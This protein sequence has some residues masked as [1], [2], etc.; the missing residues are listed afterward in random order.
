M[1]W[2]QTTGSTQR[3]SNSVTIPVM[4]WSL[5]RIH[6]VSVIMI[7]IIIN[8]LD[9]EQLVKKFCIFIGPEVQLPTTKYPPLEALMNQLNAV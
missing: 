9:G 8:I 3:G 4:A 6:G 5:E 1:M 7:I 2:G